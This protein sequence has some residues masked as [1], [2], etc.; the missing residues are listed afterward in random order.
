MA[1]PQITVTFEGWNEVPIDWLELDARLRTRVTGVV[2]DLGEFGIGAVHGQMQKFGLNRRGEDSALAN[3]ISWDFEVVR[4]TPDNFEVA[5]TLYADE[6]PE[7][8][9]AKVASIEEGRAPKSAP[10]PSDE[11]QLW[12]HDVLGST[13]R[14]ERRQQAADRRRRHAGRAEK[15]RLEGKAVSPLKRQKPR[16]V[17]AGAQGEALAEEQVA[18]LVARD[19]GIEGI[20]PKPIFGNAALEIEPEFTGRLLSALD[21]L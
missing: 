6:S 17:F 8:T 14:Q 2:R 11:M 15:A 20:A 5:G 21:D 18:F 13:I 9:A 7:N 10:P 16:S 4:N 3:S 12:V 19:I 1:E